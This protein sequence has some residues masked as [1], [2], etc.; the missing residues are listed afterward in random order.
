M[1]DPDPD[2]RPS[3]IAPVLSKLQ[4]RGPSRGRRSSRS[5]AVQDDVG[6]SFAQKAE[7]YEQHARTYE[8][9][10]AAGGPGAT[11]WLR[12]AEGW[13]NGAR[14]WR[15]AAEKQREVFT[16]EQLRRQR[17]RDRRESRRAERVER[18]RVHGHRPLRGPVALAFSLA[19]LVGM[20]AVWAATQVVV[21][22][23]LRL[24]STFFATRG[25]RAAA[26][27][28]LEAGAAAL[29][30]MERSRQW[31]FAG[32]V[33]RDGESVGPDQGSTAADG[34]RVRVTGDVAAAR[35]RVDAPA[36]AADPADEPE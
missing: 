15:V 31:V 23:L 9:R 20:V 10:A 13:R 16:R 19:F 8:Q 34:G 28:V 6:T 35:V 24:L 36:G 27:A 12:A 25:L 26:D 22:G 17:K 7:E 32:A 18:R 4:E 5:D 30:G 11:G 14:K 2:R 29:K 21:P 1:L 3:G 33:G